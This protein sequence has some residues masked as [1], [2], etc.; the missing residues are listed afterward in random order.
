MEARARRISIPPEVGPLYQ[1]LRSKYTLDFESVRVRGRQFDFLHLKDIEPLIAGRD[2]FAE[3]AE[4][5]YWVKIWEAS[6]VMADFLAHMKPNPEQCILELGSGLAVPGLVAAAFG[7]CVTISDYQDEILDFGRVSAAVNRCDG[8]GFVRLD[9]MAPA[10]VELGR[11]RV[12]IGSEVLFHPRF[13]EPLLGIFRR[14]LAPGGAIYLAHD[15]R[16]KS[17]GAFLPLCE[18]EYDIAVQK[19]TLRG[20]GETVEIL[21]TR[22]VPKGV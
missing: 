11:F 1:R 18:P 6:V 4:F 5:P 17:L 16:R 2:I 8:V 7:H 22:L 19:K 15:A 9:W 10:P 13:F 3:S 20:D 12:L 14:F 21:L